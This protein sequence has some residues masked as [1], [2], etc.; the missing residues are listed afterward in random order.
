MIP[1]FQ[2]N[3]QPILVIIAVLAIILANALPI[4]GLYT[5]EISDR[6][7]ILLVPSGYVFSI[8]GL[9]YLGL[10][11]YEIYQDSDMALVSGAAIVTTIVMLLLAVYSFWQ[12]RRV[13]SGQIYTRKTG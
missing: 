4:N 11:A 1:S 5:G 2:G 12:Q 10:I 6:F 3:N 9:I 13:A 8:W 7:D